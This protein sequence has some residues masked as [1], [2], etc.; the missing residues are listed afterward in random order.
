MRNIEKNFIAAYEENADA[1]FRHCFFR[2][3]DRERAQD[4]LQETFMKTWRH[5]HRGGSIDNLKAFL[6]KS[7]RNLIIDEYRNRSR[8][9]EDSLDILQEEEGFDPSF[10]DTEQWVDRLDGAGALEVLRKIPDAYSEMIFMRYVQ[11]LS[12]SEI[13]NITGD[14]ENSIAVRIHRGLGKLRTILHYEK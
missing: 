6:Y 13:A 7:L 4:I 10:D 11:G 3:N 5:I 14:T 2:V 9:P 8:R 12:L 1:L